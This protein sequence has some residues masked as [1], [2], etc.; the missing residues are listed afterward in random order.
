MAGVYQEI[1]SEKQKQTRIL[2]QIEILPDSI[3]R[4]TWELV[5]N[6]PT[7]NLYWFGYVTNLH[8]A[9]AIQKIGSPFCMSEPSF[10]ALHNSYNT[11]AT[12]FKTNPFK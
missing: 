3:I 12:S 4:A 11:I 8:A 5:Q 7:H 10:V 2:V 1:V 6:Q 9:Q